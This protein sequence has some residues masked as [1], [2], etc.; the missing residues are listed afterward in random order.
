MP[1]LMMS[2]IM[3]HHYHVHGYYGQ[4][5][6][7]NMLT[8]VFGPR[9]VALGMSKPLN[10]PHKTQLNVQTSD[11]A[12]QLCFLTEWLREIYNGF[13]DDLQAMKAINKSYQVLCG[14]WST[15][16]NSLCKTNDLSQ[17]RA[18]EDAI[19]E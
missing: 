11:Q 9:T 14:H 19:T 8:M 5:A 7:S 6:R 12:V 1:L 16:I 10:S 2:K 3:Q 13:N 4:L 18:F 15:D 17:I